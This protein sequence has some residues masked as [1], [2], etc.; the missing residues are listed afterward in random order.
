MVVSLLRC[1][2]QEL[3]AAMA[4]PNQQRRFNSVYDIDGVRMWCARDYHTYNAPNAKSRHGAGWYEAASWVPD[5]VSIPQHARDAARGGIGGTR[6]YGDST[7]LEP[8][9]PS[10]QRERDRRGGGDGRRC[11]GGGKGSKGGYRQFTD[12]AGPGPRPPVANAVAEVHAA[13]AYD[14]DQPLGAG[15]PR[16]SSAQ[17]LS[18]AGTPA[19]AG[20]GLDGTLAE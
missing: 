3:Q 7:G 1:S 5:G 19:H 14:P 6:P 9:V 20:D 13:R 8:W 18:V 11:K 12:P 16:P 2:V 4:F 15:R 17:R 10:A